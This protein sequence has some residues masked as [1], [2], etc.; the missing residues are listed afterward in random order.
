MVASVAAH[1]LLL[2]VP[3]ALAPQSSSGGQ[4]LTVT[5][6]A[7]PAVTGA[8]RVQTGASR[9]PVALAPAAP[10]VPIERDSALES[11]AGINLP[12]PDYYPSSR[13]SPPPRLL[14]APDPVFPESAEVDAGTVTIRL[15][16]NEQG[17]VDEALALH[18]QPPELFEQA[19]LEAFRKA[20]F[21][22]GRLLGL[23]AKAELV[24]EVQFNRL[25]PGESSAT[26]GY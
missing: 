15:R 11:K 26:R 14:Y 4:E 3:L 2:L 6:N 22:P 23:P 13:L 1:L 18:A 8:A 10:P 24:F 12:V 17:E 21:S 19:A 7:G 25:T 20:K 5:L 16:I 9:V